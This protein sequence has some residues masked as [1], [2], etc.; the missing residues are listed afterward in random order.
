MIMETFSINL[1]A[2]GPEAL[3]LILNLRIRISPAPLVN[4]VAE[5]CEVV[6]EPT[7]ALTIGV[8]QDAVSDPA[9]AAT[10]NGSDRSE[11][12]SGSNCSG[13]KL[14][15]RSKASIEDGESVLIETATLISSPALASVVGVIVNVVLLMVVSAISRW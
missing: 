7:P 12:E 9:L 6:R 11:S 2:I 8:P 15:D 4:G 5:A 13:S 1:T 14:N 10:E 3:S